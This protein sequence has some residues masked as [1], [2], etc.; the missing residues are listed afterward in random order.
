MNREEA[1]KKALEYYKGNELPANVFID[2][3]ANHNANGEYYES[4][5]NDTL[6]RAAKE[7]ARIE[8]TYKSKEKK[9]DL[10]NESVVFS[11]FKD[12]KYII[13]QGSVLSGIGLKDYTTLSNCFVLKSPY[14]SVGGIVY[15]DSEL[16]NVYKRR[17]GAGLDISNLRPKDTVVHNASKTTT[18]AVSFMERYSNTTKE[19]GMNGRRGALM[20]T[21]DVRHPD[22]FDFVNSKVDLTKINGANISV[23]VNNEFIDAVKNN[24]DFY[25]RYPVDLDLSKFTKDYIDAPYNQILYIEDHTN[26]NEICY[27]KK[28]KA[29]ELWDNIVHNNWLSAEPG[30]IFWDNQNNYSLSNKYP[31]FKNESTNPSKHWAA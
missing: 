15:T 19:I 6:M 3:Y 11:F 5:P 1:F 2:K 29:K 17:G 18:G 25:L 23:K 30:I 8:R 31:D 7:F 10:K 20:L 27:I 26:N 16:A 12:F 14:D 24:Q 21:I 28:I 9:Y 4:T 13:P 22:I